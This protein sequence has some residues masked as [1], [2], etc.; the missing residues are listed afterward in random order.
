MHNATLQ[1]INQLT[2]CF[3]ALLWDVFIRRSY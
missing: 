3:H 1:Y 2:K